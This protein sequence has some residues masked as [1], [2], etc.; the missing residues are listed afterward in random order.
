[1]AQSKYKGKVAKK[2]GGKKPAV[3]KYIAGEPV[4]AYT[5]VCHDAPAKK[6]PCVPNYSV[7]FKERKANL[8]SWRC[9][10]CNKPC[11]VKRTKRVTVEEPVAS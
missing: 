2:G 1:V 3:K 6:E 7:E 5:S 8:G 9:S 10:Q 4:F 11:K